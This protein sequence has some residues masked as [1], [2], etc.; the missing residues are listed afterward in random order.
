MTQDHPR[1]FSWEYH[2]S[3]FPSNEEENSENNIKAQNPLEVK[4]TLDSERKKISIDE[5]FLNAE[6]CIRA[7]YFYKVNRKKIQAKEDLKTLKEK[8]EKTKKIFPERRSRVSTSAVIDT[9][10]VVVQHKKNKSC[11][12]CCNVF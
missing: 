6:Y 4:D 12:I 2:I 11:V 10:S 5:N 7:K 8:I 3:I 9:N 1:P